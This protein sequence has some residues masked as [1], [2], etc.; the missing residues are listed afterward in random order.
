MLRTSVTP[1]LDDNL[2]LTASGSTYYYLKDALGSIRQLIDSSE[3]VQNSY[4]YYAFGRI[5]GT[6]TENVTQ[7][8]RFTGRAWDPES[9]LYYYRARYY[10][11]TRGHFLARDAASRLV[12]GTRS[13]KEYARVASVANGYGYVANDPVHLQDPQGTWWCCKLWKPVWQIQGD[14]TPHD[15]AARI[16][17]SQWFAKPLAA[18]G[19]NIGVFLSGAGL[20]LLA[21]EG[22]VAAWCPYA[23]GAL[24]IGPAGAYNRAIHECVKVVCQNKYRPRVVVLQNSRRGVWVRFYCPGG[25]WLI[26]DDQARR[27]LSESEAYSNFGSI[28]DQKLYP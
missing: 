28:V 19:I 14:E 21:D 6:P 1:G 23:P 18:L 5:Y 9:S 10:D 24:L 16:V 25:G 20:K 13:S 12:H 8:F 4:D 26:T 27:A 7:P 3:T 2:S 22:I 15:C 11:P 17:N